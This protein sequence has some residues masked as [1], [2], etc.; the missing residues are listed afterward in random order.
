MED[1]ND[2]QPIFSRT[3]YT[4]NV[5][6][7]AP[8]GAFVARVSAADRDEGELSERRRGQGGGGGGIDESL[9]GVLVS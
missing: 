8:V 5:S 1:V 9:E 2:N 6:E 7:R 3:V 4:A